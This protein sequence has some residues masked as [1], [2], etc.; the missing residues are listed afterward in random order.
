MTTIH[1]A[2][3]NYLTI[4]NVR[5]DSNTRQDNPRYFVVC[6]IRLEKSWQQ[7]RS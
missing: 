6:A 3:V 4:R 7:R 5:I 2:K 1:V